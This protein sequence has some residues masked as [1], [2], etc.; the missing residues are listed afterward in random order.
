MTQCLDDKMNRRI[1][2]T[3][4]PLTTTDAI[5]RAMYMPDIS[6]REKQFTEIIQSIRRNLLKVI[7][8]DDEWTSVLFSSSGTGVMESCVSSIIP[9]NKK[10][11]ILSNGIYGERFKNIANSFNLGYL[12]IGQSYKKTL[13]PKLN[14]YINKDI[15]AVFMT[16]HETTTGILNNFIE[17]KKTPLIVDAISSFGGIPISTDKPD[18]LIG[19]SCKC[20]QG[21][22]GISFVIFKK[23]YLK[24]LVKRS[25]YFDL[26]S[27]HNFQEE[28]NQ[29]RF[30]APVQVMYSFKEALN[31][32]VREGI[33][34]RYKRY[35]K[36]YKAL[37]NGMHR[38]GFKSYLPKNVQRSKLM[39]TFIQPEWFDFQHFHSEM[40]RRGFMIYP[41]VLRDKTFRLG[42]TG[43]LK[44]NDITKFLEAV[45]EI[46]DV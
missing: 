26:C 1:L 23:K 2:L 14:K 15:G 32:L 22:P 9:Q 34:K 20:I 43:D 16:H 21:L 46:Y 30:T 28:K 31:D 3:P 7:K 6:P 19:T 4:G 17:T 11:L 45:S 33:E 35:T 24:N 8:A 29:M 42:C 18:F 44:M 10:A 36:I 25:T 40:L 39:E 27:E 13:N 38:R 5:K 41:G 37:V 12:K